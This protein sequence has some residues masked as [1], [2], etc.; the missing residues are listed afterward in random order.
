MCDWLGRWKTIHVQNGIFVLGALTIAAAP[1][2][3]VVYV[4]RIIVGIASSISGIA[5]VAYLNEVAPAMFRGRLSSTYE[6]LT[7][8]G[9]L[10]AFIVDLLLAQYAN[11]WRVMFGIPALFAI[12]QSCGMILL[13]ES[14]K[15]LAQKGRHEDVDTVLSS[16]YGSKEAASD[17]YHEIDVEIEDEKRIKSESQHSSALIANNALYSDSASIESRSKH[18]HDSNHNN[19]LFNATNTTEPMCPDTRDLDA[20]DVDV[21]VP[22]DQHDDFII[23]QFIEY[24]LPLYVLAALQLCSQ[25]SGM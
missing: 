2:V 10:L 23:Q 3:N 4:G 22:R 8:I 6:F 21:L 25:L 19:N 14:P 12:L 7:C 15:W 1:N 20:R 11:G 5:D 16:I 13:P 24:Q 18:D 9:V 17:A